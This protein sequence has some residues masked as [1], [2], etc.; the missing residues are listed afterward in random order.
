M[1]D[2]KEDD[3]QQGVRCHNLLFAGLDIKEDA[4]SQS[5][6][7]SRYRIAKCGYSRTAVADHVMY[8]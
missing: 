1:S 2:L 4:S 5:P 7:V 3:P 6:A 8:V